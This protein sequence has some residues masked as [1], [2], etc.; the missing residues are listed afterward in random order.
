MVLS[1]FG[2]VRT[3][4]KLRHG[5]SFFILGHRISYASVHAS[6]DSTTVDMSKLFL[7]NQATSAA[8]RTSIV[9]WLSVLF[10]TWSYLRNDCVRLDYVR[11]RC[12]SKTWVDAARI[13][14]GLL[15]W[16]FPGHGHWLSSRRSFLVS[17]KLQKAESHWKS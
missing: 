16:F 2:S 17:H 4:R 5:L 9:K 14:A 11:Q 3:S 1:S 12:S 13:L 6:L 15:P 7:W 8:N 10:C